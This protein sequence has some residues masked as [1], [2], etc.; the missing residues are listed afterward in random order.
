MA[1]QF[2]RF[3][4]FCVRVARIPVGAVTRRHWEGQEN[5][6]KEGGFVAVGKPYFR[7]RLHDHDA[8]YD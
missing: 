3:Y 6:P 4:K 2:S 7:V 5:L 8:L 1:G